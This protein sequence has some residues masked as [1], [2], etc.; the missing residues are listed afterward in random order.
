MT[1]HL[2]ISFGAGVLLGATSVYCPGFV[3][4]DRARFPIEATD[5]LLYTAFRPNAMLHEPAVQ[6]ALVFLT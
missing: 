1:V 3:L 4:D 2:E 5:F 6:G